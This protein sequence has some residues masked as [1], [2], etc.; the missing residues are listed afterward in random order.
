MAYVDVASGMSLPFYSCPYERCGFNTADRGLFLQHVV[1][2]V[3]DM[4]HEAIFDA[5]SCEE[6]E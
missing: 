5:L 1:A 4:M 3:S 2:G 6:Q